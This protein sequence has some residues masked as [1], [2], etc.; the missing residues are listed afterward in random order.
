MKWKNIQWVIIIVLAIVTVLGIFSYIGKGKQV[1]DLKNEKSSIKIPDKKNYQKELTQDEVAK[2]KDVVEGKLDDYKERSLDEGTFNTNNSGVM[3]VKALFSPPGG[4]AITEET[5]IEK[6][7]KYY[8]S[9]KYKIKD[10]SATKNG[11]GGTD[12]YFRIDMKQEGNDV[13][14]QY[15]LVK[16]QFNKDNDMVGGSI[17]AK[18]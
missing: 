17:Y 7:V 18:Q 8:S 14:P 15:D 1:D 13:N 6:Y 16:L 3:T 12:V 9:F 5:S 11:S 10:I 2:Y 4:Y